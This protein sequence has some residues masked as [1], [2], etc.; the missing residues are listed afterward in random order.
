MGVACSANSDAFTRK[1]GSPAGF[2]SFVPTPFHV[3]ADS[4]SASSIT[5]PHAGID[6]EA[7]TEYFSGKDKCHSIKIGSVRR[8]D[9][10]CDLQATYAVRWHVVR[11]HAHKA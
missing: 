7:F 9:E 6:R 11:E 10:P 8:Y 5:Q 1:S 2:E 4:T 3:S